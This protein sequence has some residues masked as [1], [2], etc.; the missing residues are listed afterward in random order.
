MTPTKLYPRQNMADQKQLENLRYFSSS[1]SLVTNDAWAAC[2]IK[3][4]ISTAKAAFKKK[5][6]KKYKNISLTSKM[7]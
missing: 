6:R 4:G 2:E 5:S 1:V 3:S 7:G